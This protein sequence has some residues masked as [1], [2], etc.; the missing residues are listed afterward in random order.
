[1]PRKYLPI[2]AFAVYM[3]VTFLLNFVGPWSYS[4]INYLLV[5]VFL[6]VFLS[7]VFFAYCIAV[8]RNVKVIA[9]K[10]E[11]ESIKY[12]RW[13]LVVASALLTLVITENVLRIG[14]PNFSQ[15]IGTIMAETY[16]DKVN[17]DFSIS[18]WLQSYLFVLVIF[19]M[20]GG[21]YFF[22]RLAKHLGS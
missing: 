12:L 17:R 8:N 14:L 4:G 7:F 22:L 1:M 3:V 10:T 20:V 15:S 19:S 9:K 13:L 16:S 6:F 2:I 5:L 18:V 11:R 21:A